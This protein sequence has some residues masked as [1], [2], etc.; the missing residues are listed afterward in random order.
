MGNSSSNFGLLLGGFL[1]AIGLGVAGFFVGEGFVEGRKASH[2]VTVK[3]LAEKTVRADV[4]NWPMR[5]SAAGDDLARTQAKIESDT[6]AVIAF[7]TAGGIPAEDIRPQRLEVVDQLAQ[8]YRSGQIQ[9]NRFILNRTVLV[10]TK[11]VN[12]VESLSSDTGPI[13][14]EG[15]VLS[16]VMGPTY[17]FTR[18]N[19]IKPEMIAE[20]TRSARASAEQFAGDSGARVGSIMRANQ[21][22]FQIL[23]L[24]PDPMSGGEATQ[25]DK[26]VRVVTTVDYELKD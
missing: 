19:D 4:A 15:V 11:Q 12:V 21:G 22:Y 24:V 26:L 1:V 9:G 16:D 2:Y 10:R 18:L 20:A 23:P 8:Q 17:T 14:R 13:V 5:F 7:L 25:I 3:G 6:K